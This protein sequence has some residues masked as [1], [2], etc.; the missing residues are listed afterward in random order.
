[1]SIWIKVKKKKKYDPNKL[2]TVPE[3]VVYIDLL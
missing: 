1:M 2:K 3:I